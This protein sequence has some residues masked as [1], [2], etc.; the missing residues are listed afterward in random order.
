[1]DMSAW[2]LDRLLPAT[3]DRFQEL[4]ARTATPNDRAYALAE[5][6]DFLR[7][8]PRAELERAIA[9]APRARL[10]PAVLNHLAAAVE[11]AAQRRGVKAPAWTA[12]V[13]IPNAPTFGSG[14]SSVRLQLLTHTPVALRRR[15]LFMDAAF[16]QRV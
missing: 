10:E 14:L 13:A 9:H 5:L 1:M 6:A 4:V 3:Q 16:D 15:N 2:I 7:A 8:L 11:L 12:R